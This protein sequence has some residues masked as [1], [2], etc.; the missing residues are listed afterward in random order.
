MS[1]VPDP[2]AWKEGVSPS[3]RP[4]RD[5]RISPVRFHKNAQQGHGIRRPVSGSCDSSLATKR[6]VL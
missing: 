1:L 3:M 6:V 4:A 2:L 5:V